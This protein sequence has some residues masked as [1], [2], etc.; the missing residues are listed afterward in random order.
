M[1]SQISLTAADAAEARSRASGRLLELLVPGAFWAMAL[2]WAVVN[3]LPPINFDEALILTI[4]E[5]WLGGERL[6]VDLID[7]NPP[8]IFILNLVPAAIERITG[9]SGPIS[10]VLSVLAY[11]GVAIWLSLKLLPLVV[12]PEDSTVKLVLPPLIV[13]A[14]VI[15]AGDMLGQREHLMLA[16]LTPYMLLAAARVRE[17]RMPLARRIGVTIFATIGFALKPHFL[18]IP[19]LIELYV[20]VQRGP[21][22]LRDPTPWLMAALIA[23]YPLATW[24]WLPEYYTQVLPLV[25]SAYES[26]GTAD[27]STILF[28]NQLAPALIV[29][30][31][32]GIAAFVGRF[33]TLIR[34]VVLASIGASISGVAQ[35]KGWPYHLLP[36]QTLAIMLTALM[37]A[38]LIDTAL[39]ARRR[40][41]PADGAGAAPGPMARGVIGMV[42]LGFVS[43][44]VYTRSTFYDQWGYQDTISAQLVKIVKPYADGKSILVISPGVYPIFPMLNYAHAKMA[45]RFE[46]IWPLQGAY[47]GCAITDPRYHDAE[48]VTLSERVFDQAMIEDFAKYRPP[49]VI[50]DK[51][52]G[53]DW[54][55]GKDFDLL[56][57]FLKKPKFAAEMEHYELLQNYDRYLIY[58]RL[59]DGEDSQ[60]D[61]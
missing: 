59:P 51:D 33:S 18:I 20:L 53:I 27:Y 19:A 39:A 23:L 60:T 26:I 6:Y 36:A 22:A 37:V 61:Q 55:G 12:S 1:T 7:V 31:P 44:S 13:V 35:G 52:P 9:L 50:I 49:L 40:Q 34:V 29:L 38:A 32:L 25:M 14:L 10:L 5:R 11:V 43:L 2:V 17:A 24:I 30:I 54:C 16:S 48:H 42:L 57:Y 45:M 21:K 4:S 28:G 56:E 46:T 8:L 41:A 15:F 3:L 47:N 58:K